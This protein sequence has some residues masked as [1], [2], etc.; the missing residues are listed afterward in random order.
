MG[1]TSLPATS[2]PLTRRAAPPQGS[3]RWLL[4][5]GA[6][7]L[8]GTALG[9]C[10]PGSAPAAP[11]AEQAAPATLKPATLRVYEWGA[12]EGPDGEVALALAEAYRQR[13][14]QITITVEHAVGEDH[15]RKLETLFAAGDPPDLINTQSWRWLA[16]AAK[17]LLAPLDELRRRDRFDQAWPPQWAALYD[18]QT[19]FRGRLYAR[20]YHMGGVS[21]V[22][23]TTLFDRFGIP[24]PSPQWT[25]ADFLDLA[26]RLT[27]PEGDTQ[28]FGFQSVRIYTRWFGWWRS[29]GQTEWDR[30]VEPT[31]A[32]WTLPTVLE[33]LDFLMREAFHTLR[34]SPTP[35]EQGQGVTIE[36]GR[37]AMKVEGPWFLP[38]MWGPR[39]AV[40]PGVPF[41]VV[42][43]PRG[44]GGRRV[45]AGVGHTHTISAQ[46]KHLEA[47]WDYLKFI[48]TDP[49]QELVARI[50]GRQPI[51]PQQNLTIWVPLVQRLYNFTTAAAFVQSLEVGQ[52]HLAG[53]LD[54]GVLFRDSG[55]NDAIEALIRGERRASEVIPEA[56]RRMQQLLDDYWA[57]QRR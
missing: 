6:G 37:V 39:A 17:G 4:A 35:A 47:T 46:T 8:G 25:F 30:L 42:P 41:E 16:Y 50:T 13:Q 31:R 32:Q 28:Y 20:P 34:V 24:R 56:N 44:Q 19:Q 5:A 3:R 45:T 48:A 18:P 11:G 10:R 38:T 26:R 53:E 43:L 12:P 36:R 14:P 21:V 33:R 2:L 49:A 29:E 1:A 15:Y 9:A 57:R 23:S 52:F 54:E 55:F 27:R 7:L 22:Y 51:T 40:Q